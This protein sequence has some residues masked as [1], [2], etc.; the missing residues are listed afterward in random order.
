M[1]H[2]FMVALNLAQHVADFCEG[3]AH[4]KDLVCDLN[5]HWSLL[6]QPLFLLAFVSHPQCV[7]LGC[8]LLSKSVLLHG[9]WLQ[10]CNQM[11]KACLCK[12]VVFH[13]SKFKLHNSVDPEEKSAEEQNLKKQWNLQINE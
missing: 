4:A 5:I 13:C 10:Q 2:V 9:G 11:S 12:A 1:A 3:T 7:E 6:E 8:R